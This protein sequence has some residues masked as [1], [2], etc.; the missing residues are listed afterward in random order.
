MQHNDK[1]LSFI[2]PSKDRPFNFTYK[3]Q[4]IESKATVIYK[5]KTYEINGK[6]GGIDFSKGYPP[7]HTI[8]NWASISGVSSSGIPIGMNLFRGHNDKYENAAWIGEERMLL[9][10]TDFIY[11][12]NKPL[13][14][15]NWQLKT[16]D[17]LVDL[18]FKPSY[19]R[20]EKINTGVLRH[21]FIQPFGVFEGTI[22]HN[23]KIHDFTGYGPVEEHESLW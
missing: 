22:N 11:D 10:N 3:N 6:F 7:R 17:G 12:K 14:K 8:W 4:N 20:K 9:S 23:G 18:V 2:C 5:N 1:G 21:D 16:E 15:Q 19:A 13:D